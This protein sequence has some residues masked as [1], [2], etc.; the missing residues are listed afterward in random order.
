VL[1]RLGLTGV[2]NTLVQQGRRLR[3]HQALRNQLRGAIR[4]GVLALTHNDAF[5]D[6]RKTQA[7]GV[8]FF[9]PLVGVE[10]NLRG[11]QARGVVA[12]GGEYERLRRAIC[13]R[14]P[15]LVDPLTGAAVCR[16][17][18]MFHGPHLERF[19]D[20]VAVLDPSYDGK[21]QLHRDVLAENALN[22][23]YPFMGYHAQ[24]GIFAAVGTGIAAGRVLPPADM[25]DLAP[26]VLRLLDVPVPATMEG[27]PFPV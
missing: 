19:P 18:E 8:E 15:A 21:V 9:Y 25:L 13:E 3:L 7:Y 14:L 2:T 22:W 10:V 20:V 26:T 27:S 1:D 16:R 24:E 23:E 11:R 12:P 5:V 6:F 4:E 17:E